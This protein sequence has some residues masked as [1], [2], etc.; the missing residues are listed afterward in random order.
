VTVL[1]RCLVI[2][3]ASE[4]RPQW[5]DRCLDSVRRWAAAADYGY[6]FLGDE[7]FDRVPAELR[8]KLAERTPVLADLARLLWLRDCHA[9]GHEW[10]MWVDADTLV[11]D[12]AWRPSPGS[13]TQFGEECWLQT[14]TK[15]RLEVRY[16][17]H[18]AYLLLHESS[19]VRDFLIFAVESLLARVD[20]TK[21]APQFVGPKLLKALHNIAQ[22][23]LEPAAGALSPL[24]QTAL[25]EGGE[26]IHSWPANRALAMANLCTSLETPEGI[27][28]QLINHSD[29]VIQRLSRT[30]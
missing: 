25:V 30:F 11:L 28:E 3:S 29:E 18:N 21:L 6:T 9:A 4:Q 14:N 26:A 24:L 23:E 13:H 5:V 7:L 10:V 27:R 19:P 1:R 16:Q 17:P 20:A 22:F 15:G 2:Q 8:D 12:P